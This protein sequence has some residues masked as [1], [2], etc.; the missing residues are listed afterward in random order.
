MLR[1]MTLEIQSVPMLRLW[2]WD[3]AYLLSTEN[4]CE[5]SRLFV[6][7]DRRGSPLVNSQTTERERGFQ[8]H[9]EEYL[10]KIEVQYRVWKKHSNGMFT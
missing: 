10:S 1:T 8:V 3:P 5:K 4:K 7:C 9:A 6:H 2:A